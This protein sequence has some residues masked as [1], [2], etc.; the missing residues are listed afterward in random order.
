MGYGARMNPR[1]RAGGKPA[2]FTALHRIWRAASV[3]ARDRAGLDRW[4][5]S[6]QLSEG[7]RAAIVMIWDQQNPQDPA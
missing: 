1:S 3:Y 5:D 6:K 7:D 4:M 2:P